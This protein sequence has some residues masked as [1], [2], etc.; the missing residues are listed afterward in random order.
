MHL[1]CDFFLEHIALSAATAVVWV[2]VIL[3]QMFAS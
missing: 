1:E 3:K 2:N